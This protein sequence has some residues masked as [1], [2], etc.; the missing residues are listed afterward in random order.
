[1]PADPALS[2]SK[3][4]EVF[5]LRRLT[6]LYGVAYSFYAFL[7]LRWVKPYAFLTLRDGLWL[8]R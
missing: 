8:T 7:F 6:E 1:M 3:S 2:K 5:R 4:H